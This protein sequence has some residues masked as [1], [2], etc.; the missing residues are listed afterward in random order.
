VGEHGM[1]MIRE[2]S[3]LYTCTPAEVMAIAF[4]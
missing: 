3:A 2:H 4:G 1:E